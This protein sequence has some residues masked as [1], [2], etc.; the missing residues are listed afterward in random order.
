MTVGSSDRC[1]IFGSLG[2]MTIGSAITGILG[3][4]GGIKNSDGRPSVEA[5]YIGVGLCAFNVCLLVAMSGCCCAVAG[6]C[7]VSMSGCCRTTAEHVQ[8][9]CARLFSP[10]SG[11]QREPAAEPEAPAVE[12]GSAPVQE[13]A[14]GI[15]IADDPN[16]P[17]GEAA[18]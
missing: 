14:D 8:K 2:F 12:N 9:C 6:R 13:I 17:Y 18:Q 3:F 16:L 5:G 4:T 11:S 7:A 1:I 15:V 10:I